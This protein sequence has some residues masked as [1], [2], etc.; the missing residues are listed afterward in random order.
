MPC[1]AMPWHRVASHR[2]ASHHITLK[3]WLRKVVDTHGVAAAVYPVSTFWQVHDRMAA[4]YPISTFWRLHDRMAAFYPISKFWQL[5]DRWQH[6]TLSAH[7]GDSKS[8]MDEHQSAY[9]LKLQQERMGLN[10]PPT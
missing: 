6:S 8:R 5:H 1:H 10:A 9:L 2:I 3:L 4:F 7:F